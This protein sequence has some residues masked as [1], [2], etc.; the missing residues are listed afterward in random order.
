MQSTGE[1]G[2][3]TIDTPEQEHYQTDT[4]KN[5]YMS[6]DYKFY[7]TNPNYFFK[8]HFHHSRKCGIM[9]ELA[10]FEGAKLPWKRF[11]AM[12]A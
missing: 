6:E 4:R 12:S 5:R 9:H 2:T 10:F 11:A 7:Q 1:T 8:K 3:V